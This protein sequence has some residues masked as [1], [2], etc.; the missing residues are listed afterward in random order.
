M[1]MLTYLKNRFIYWVM[2][3]ERRFWGMS[4]KPN[5]VSDAFKA[6]Y[7]AKDETS[8]ESVVGE[9]LHKVQAN[10]RTYESMVQRALTRQVSMRKRVEAVRKA[11]LSHEYCEQKT[12]LDIMNKELKLHG[13]HQ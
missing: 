1:G 10:P 6:V 9:K 5:E 13:S 11:R 12:Q 4:A 2:A 3:L 8:E 7:E